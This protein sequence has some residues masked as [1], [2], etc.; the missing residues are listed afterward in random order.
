MPVRAAMPHATGY[1]R[2]LRYSDGPT[3]AEG[4]EEG[5]DRGNSV[6]GDVENEYGELLQDGKGGVVGQA[7]PSGI[8]CPWKLG[9]HIP[10]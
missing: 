5:W 8:A 10:D 1:T 9:L 3:I 2:L 7:R 4:G 6:R